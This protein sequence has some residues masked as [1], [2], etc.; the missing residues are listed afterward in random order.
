L[1]VGVLAAGRL[2]DEAKNIAV[3]DQ[4]AAVMDVPVKAAGSSAGPNGAAV[5]FA[6]LSPLGVLDEA[7]MAAAMRDARIFASPALYEPF[8]LAVLEAAQAARP[9]VLADIPSFR[10]LWDG[11]ALFLPPRDAAAWARA[12][13]EL[14][15]NPE[16]CRRLGAAAQ[17]RAAEYGATRFADAMWQLL[18]AMSCVTAA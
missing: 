5:E 9:L 10:E 13:T 4:A 8:G 12:L 2:W 3:L 6:S 7:A 16:A 1:G 15:A 11:A 14:H 18:C 17:T